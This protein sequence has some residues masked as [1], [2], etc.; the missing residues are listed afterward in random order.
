MMIRDSHTELVSV[1]EPCQVVMSKAGAAILVNGVRLRMEVEEARL[2]EEQGK[3]SN[4]EEVDDVEETIT[5][6]IDVRNFFNSTS[7][8]SIISGLEENDNLQHLAWAA[9]VQLAPHHGLESG[10]VQWG[11]AGEGTT[12]G[13]TA[14]PPWACISWH[15]FV[16]E[17]HET[18]VRTGGQ[19]LFGMDDGYLQGKPSILFPALERFAAQILEYCGLELEPSKCEVY[20]LKGH[21]PPQAPPN[22]K[23]S[24]V[25]VGSSWEQGMIVYGVP[26]GSDGYVSHHL[27]L[28]VDEIAASAKRCSEVLEGEAQCLFSV[29]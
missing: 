11:E 24:K 17:L 4:G 20:S 10:G 18:L 15:R 19:A 22:F 26:V 14:A 3:R 9:A 25:K 21:L 29:L 12:Q 1:F 2:E 16:M 8:A 13:D 5:V 28:K 23:V 7:R 27:N 6:K